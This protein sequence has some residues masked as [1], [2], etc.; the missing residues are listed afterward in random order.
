MLEKFA[1]LGSLPK[2][3]GGF[4]YQRHKPKETELYKII[5]QNLPSS[6]IFLIPTFRFRL[7]FTMNS[8]ATFNAECSSMVFF[9]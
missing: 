4:V 9:A 8:V 7:L 6:P 2:S 3:P 1:H 5:E